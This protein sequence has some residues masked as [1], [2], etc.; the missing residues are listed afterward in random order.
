M[1]SVSNFI[2]QRMRGTDFSLQRE[3]AIW[4]VRRESL[5]KIRIEIGRRVGSLMLWFVGEIMRALIREVAVG[6]DRG[7]QVYLRNIFQGHAIRNQWVIR[8]WEMRT[9]QR[10]SSLRTWEDDGIIHQVLFLQWLSPPAYKYDIIYFNKQNSWPT[11]PC[12]LFFFS[13]SHLEQSFYKN[14][15]L[16]SILNF[17]PHSFLNSS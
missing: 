3:R 6:M 9:G 2:Q 8:L 17:S 1:L 10:I 5:E 16:L 15:F 12:T 14:C 13:C 11:F 4:S 7:C